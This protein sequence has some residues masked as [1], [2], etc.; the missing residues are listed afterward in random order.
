MTQEKKIAFLQKR[1]QEFKNR[2]IELTEENKALLL[3]IQ[4]LEKEK[5]SRQQH[6]DDVLDEADELRL[7]YIKEIKSANEAKQ[8]Y[9]KS[10]IEIKTLKSH[11]R[12]EMDLF[13][14]NMRKDN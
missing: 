13:L 1:A 5:A 14:K 6:L 10:I 9:E 4:S 2:V 12:K 7:Q 11:Y 3:K 8:A